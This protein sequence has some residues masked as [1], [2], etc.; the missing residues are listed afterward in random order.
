[1][2]REALEQLDR[3]ETVLLHQRILETVEEEEKEH[4]VQEELEVLVLL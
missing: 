1:M 4:P 3:M 2:P